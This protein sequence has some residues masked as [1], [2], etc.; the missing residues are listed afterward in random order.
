MFLS[1]AEGAD[2]SASEI[3]G[4]AQG[5][6][7]LIFAFKGGAADGVNRLALLIHYIV[8]FEK[9]FAGIEVLGFNG[10]LR[11]LDTPRNEL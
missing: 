2:Q 9:M 11:V 6:F 8:V 10:L 3:F 1:R 5:V 7:F 4:N